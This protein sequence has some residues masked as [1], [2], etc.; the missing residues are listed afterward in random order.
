MTVTMMMTRQYCAGNSA[1]FC[2]DNTRR[3]RSTTRRVMFTALV[4]FTPNSRCS[5]SC[6]LQALSMEAISAS[7]NN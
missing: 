5:T 1:L 4:T 3:R 2:E 7:T 6:E